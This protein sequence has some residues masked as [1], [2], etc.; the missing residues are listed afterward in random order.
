MEVLQVAIEMLAQHGK[1]VS[2]IFFAAIIPAVELPRG[3]AIG[4]ERDGMRE[5]H[6]GVQVENEHL[7]AIEDRKDVT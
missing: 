3:P 7:G 1:Y 4:V 5:G 6:L 2:V